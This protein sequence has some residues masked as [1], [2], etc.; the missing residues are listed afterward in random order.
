MTPGDMGGEAKDD[1][2][3]LGKG[4]PSGLSVGRGLEGRPGLRRG[5]EIDATLRLA[6]LMDASE[7]VGLSR[8]LREVAGT[9]WRGD[10]GRPAYWR[11]DSGTADAGAGATC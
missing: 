5:D 7:V 6:A 2:G 9:G 10:R 3:C 11:G 4:E 1:L 8:A